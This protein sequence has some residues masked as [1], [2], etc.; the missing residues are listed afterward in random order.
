M[1]PLEDYY[2][3]YTTVSKG[4]LRL[5]LLPTPSWIKKDYVDQGQEHWWAPVLRAETSHMT[6]EV[7]HPYG[8]ILS[9]AVTVLEISLWVW[10]LSFSG[11]FSSPMHLLLLEGFWPLLSKTFSTPITLRLWQMGRTLGGIRQ[12][13]Y[14]F[15]G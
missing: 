1:P 15:D 5:P 2:L 10:F 13:G 11:L 7:W 14:K 4:G 6:Q 8:L 12:A 9:S 3:F